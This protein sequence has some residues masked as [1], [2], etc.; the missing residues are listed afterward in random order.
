MSGILEVFGAGVRAISHREPVDRAIYRKF[1]NWD[2]WP[3][4]ASSNRPKVAHFLDTCNALHGHP[5]EG[6]LETNLAWWER[7]F[8]GTPLCIDE[9]DARVYL[10]VLWGPELCIG[11]L[12]LTE[13]KLAAL[14]PLVDRRQ[15][16]WLGKLVP[17]TRRGAPHAIRDHRIGKAGVITGKGD[18]VPSQGVCWM[19]IGDR[20]I[21]LDRADGNDERTYLDRNP[22]NQWLATVLGIAFAGGNDSHAKQYAAAFRRRGGQL[23]APS[24]ERRVAALAALDGLPAQLAEVFLWQ[25]DVPLPKHTSEVGR[26]PAGLWCWF[27]HTKDGTTQGGSGAASD[28]FGDRWLTALPGARES[29]GGPDNVQPCTAVIEVLD[30]SRLIVAWPDRSPA[31]HYAMALP[32]GPD[33]FRARSGPDGL[34]VLVPPGHSAAPPPAPAEPSGPGAE[35]PDPPATRPRKPRKSRPRR[36]IGRWFGIAKSMLQGLP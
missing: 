29:K 6:K 28:E 36:F 3:V 13:P 17:K 8:D 1:I 14:L 33:T 10:S 35:E 21:V 19:G 27:L 16:A 2:R 26:T 12:A 11:S 7:T 32:S 22:V 31:N 18:P 4:D 20:S 23:W 30:E 24:D 9:E 34:V 5:S 15:Y 25:R